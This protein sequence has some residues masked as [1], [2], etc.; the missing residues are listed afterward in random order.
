[1]SRA[2]YLE[3]RPVEDALK[4]WFVMF[5]PEGVLKPLQAYQQDW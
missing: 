1:M 5:D 3:S 4:K 2:I